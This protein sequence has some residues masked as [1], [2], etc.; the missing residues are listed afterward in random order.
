MIKINNDEVDL[1][2]G[3][4][5]GQHVVQLHQYLSKVLGRST[6]Q[7]NNWFRDKYVMISMDPNRWEV[8][9]YI[10]DGKHGGAL[11]RGSLYKANGTSSMNHTCLIKALGMSDSL[12]A[13]GAQLYNSSIDYDVTNLSSMVKY[14]DDL[15]IFHQQ[16]EEERVWSLPSLSSDRYNNRK[17]KYATKQQLVAEL[18]HLHVDGS[19]SSL[20]TSSSSS[21]NK[22]R[23]PI[24]VCGDGRFKGNTH[25]HILQEL[26]KHAVVIIVNEAYTSKHC[27]ECTNVPTVMHQ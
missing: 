8:I 26:S 14:F 27:H 11:T 18:L 17:L 19:S 20:G 25:Q 6:N 2:P 16:Q 9:A 15:D 24:F 21:S 10:V 22:Q 7:I 13:A 5:Y 3:L 1:Q 23:V 12:R 4:Y